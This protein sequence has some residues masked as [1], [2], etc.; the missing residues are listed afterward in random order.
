MRAPMFKDM[1][2]AGK[3]AKG[4]R[5]AKGDSAKAAIR[6]GE[7]EDAAERETQDKKAED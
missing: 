6:A 2:K 4:T 7:A 3:K 1:F 5:R